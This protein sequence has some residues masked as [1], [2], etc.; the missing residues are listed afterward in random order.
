MRH[1]PCRCA[2]RR[3]GDLRAAGRL[4]T[5]RQLPP[6]TR[7]RAATEPR[8]QPRRGRCSAAAAQ[9][10]DEVQHR[11]SLN[12]VLAGLLLVGH[13]LA[14]EDEA[15]LRRRDPLLLLHALLDPRDE[16]VR[17]D[18]NLNLLASER[19]HLDLWL[20]AGGVGVR[21]G[22]QARHARPN[23]PPPFTG[24]QQSRQRRAATLRFACRR[25]V[26][27]G[28]HARPRGL[29]AQEPMQ[30][31][32]RRVP[33][34]AYVHGAAARLG[35]KVARPESGDLVCRRDGGAL[36]LF[37]VLVSLLARPRGWSSPPAHQRPRV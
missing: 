25:M 12:V 4:C 8:P 26:V 9:S 23:A 31:A 14:S 35:G 27:T 33:A 16:V 34:C 30:A 15:L 29:R 37:G 18:V 28:R 6:R 2:R 36:S 19:L 13:L 24:S 5:W 21:C 20:A 17:L 3:R 1:M 22:Q 11:A 10:E 7:Q 32:L